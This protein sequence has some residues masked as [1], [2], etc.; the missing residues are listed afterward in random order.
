M[1]L[2]SPSEFVENY[3]A[4]GEKKTSLS[5]LKLFLLGILAGFFI[6]LGA[7]ASSTAAFS[8]T[9]VSVIRTV[10]GLIFPFGLIMVVLTG[11][12]LFT[13]NC[14]ITISVLSKRATILKMLRNLGIVYIGNFVGSILVSAGCAYFGQYDYSAG[15]LAVYTIKIASAK[16][17]LPFAN[18]FVSGIF[19]NILVCVAVMLSLCAKDVIGRAAGAYIP[20]SFFVICGFEH[21]V[22]NMYYISAGLLA[23]SIPQYAKLALDAGLDLSKLSWGNFFS[24]NLLPVTLG[25]IVGGVAFAAIMWLCHKKPK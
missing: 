20:I 21:C 13:G 11:S 5:T 16:C 22:A 14:L 9:N 24:A 6:A 15:A 17:A 8:F 23:E 7:A 4:A 12:E 3:A 1:N 10:S 25:N 2:F 19:C 18:A